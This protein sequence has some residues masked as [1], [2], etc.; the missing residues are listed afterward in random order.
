MRDSFQ[1]V[2]PYF[3]VSW[4]ADYAYNKEKTIGASWNCAVQQ[5]Q[6][7]DTWLCIMDDDNEFHP[8]FGRL[9]SETI[10]GDHQNTQLY[11]LRQFRGGVQNGH[12][13]GGQNK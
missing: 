12:A 9:M 5:I 11:L 4:F 13:H 3:D 8:D 6:D 7:L 10:K 2:N 1:Y